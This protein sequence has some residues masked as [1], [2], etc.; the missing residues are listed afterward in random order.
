MM[1][2]NGPFS[3][4][5]NVSAEERAA[6]APLLLGLDAPGL[7]A[8]LDAITAQSIDQAALIDDVASLVR[9]AYDARAIGLAEFRLLMGLCSLRRFEADGALLWQQQDVETNRLLS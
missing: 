1:L 7:M 9:G 8:R 3:V 6:S 4:E 5:E 2:P